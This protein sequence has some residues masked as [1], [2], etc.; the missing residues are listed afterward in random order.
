MSRSLDELPSIQLTPRQ[1]CEFELLATGALHPLKHFMGREELETVAAGGGASIVLSHNDPCEEGRELLLRDPHNL[2]LAVLQVSE[3]FRWNGSWCL[4][5][6]MDTLDLPKHS[7]FRHLRRSPSEV[8]NSLG[9]AAALGVMLRSFPDVELEHALRCWNGPTLLGIAAGDD[10]YFPLVRAAK[11]IA[12][13]SAVVAVVPVTDRSMD[14]M[15]LKNYGAS[16][17]IEQRPGGVLSPALTALVA[18]LTPPRHKQGFCVWFTGLPSA[19]K[20]TIAELV[21]VR[22]QERGRI[23]TLLDGDVVRTHLST[24]LGFSREDR[25]T[26]IFRI[27]Y[28]ASEIVRHQGAVICAAVSPYRSARERARQMVGQGHFFEVYVSTPSEVCESR[29]V[30]GYYAKARTGKIHGMTGVDDPYEPP[31]HAEVTLTTIGTAPEADAERVL[32]VLEKA[33]FVRPE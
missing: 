8:R 14:P 25:D 22:L 9:G 3:C 11:L 13:D 32:A 31:D 4:S 30:K 33:G 27:G 7:D 28:V 17:V 29:D 18:E 23:C 26:N 20:S 24:G 19:G 15:V 16:E 1:V 12:G 5:G 6:P 21:A 10:D 2:R